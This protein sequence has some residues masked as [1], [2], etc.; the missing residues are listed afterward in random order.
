MKALWGTLLIGFAAVNVYA[1][2]TG[3]LSDLGDYLRNLGPWGIL[4]TIDL[5]LALTIGVSWMWDDARAKGI[6]PLPYAVLTVV[7]GSL[8]LLLYLV[9]HGSAPR[10][11]EQVPGDHSS[12]RLEAA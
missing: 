4:A 9:R 2:A 6:A 11:D 10:R 3:S 8:G 5:L 12:S 7:T 1:F